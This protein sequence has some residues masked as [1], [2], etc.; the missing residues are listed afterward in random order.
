VVMPG[1]QGKEVAERVR[2][3]R[4]EVRVLYMSGY[5]H[6]LLGVQ[7]V[8]EPGVHLLEKPFSET[9]LLAKLHV[10][11]ARALPTGPPRRRARAWPAGPRRLGRPHANS[12]PDGN[13]RLFISYFGYMSEYSR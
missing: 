10:V 11:L 12:R 7:G 8:L 5:T 4:P 9:S 2:R 13:R 6:G 1:M 3:L